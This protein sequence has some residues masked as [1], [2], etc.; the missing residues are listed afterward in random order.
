MQS[1]EKILKQYKKSYEYSLL[2]RGIKYICVGHYYVCTS[3]TLHFCPDCNHIWRIEPYKILNGA[4]CP[5]C[6]WHSLK[7]EYAKKGILS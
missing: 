5:N 7:T 3:K 2:K 1:V 6:E 4:C